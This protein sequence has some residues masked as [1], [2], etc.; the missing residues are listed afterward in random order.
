[1]TAI[2]RPQHVPAISSHRPLIPLLS[3]L[4]VAL[5]FS[6]ALADRSAHHDDDHAH[7]TDTGL[8][9]YDADLRYILRTA[10]V[11]GGLAFIGKRIRVLIG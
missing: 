6:F 4:A 5:V 7:A 3:V 10:H 8:T 9:E 1:M 2:D 11:D